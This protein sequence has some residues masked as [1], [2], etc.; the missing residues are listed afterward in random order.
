MNAQSRIR[1]ALY[2]L[3]KTFGLSSEAFSAEVLSVEV[4]TR[5][6][7]VRSISSETEVEYANVWLMPE[8]SDGILQIPA[9][10]STVIIQN[11][12]NLQPYVVMWSTISELLYVV[13]QTVFTMTDGLTKF[14]EGSNDGL[15]NIKPLVTKINA[16]ENLLNDLITQFNAHT[17]VTSC[18]AGGGSAAATL[19][20]ETGTIAPITAQADLEDTKVVH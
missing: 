2:S 4:N 1:N 9:V 16:V 5:S 14:N 10:G 7:T 15:V 18:P 20:P 17:H 3:F 11:N 12:K 13:N 19:T 8:Q 6:C